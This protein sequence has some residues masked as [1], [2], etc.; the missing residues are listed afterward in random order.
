MDCSA[1]V[2]S[3]WGI[4]RYTTESIGWVSFA[5]AKDELRPGDA[6]NL[7]I[8]RDPEGFGH[9]RLFEAW[10]NEAHTLVWV[11]EETPPRAVHRVV[12]YDDRYQPIRLASLS[13]AAA[14]PLVPAPPPAPEPKLVPT[15]RRSTPS[16]RPTPRVTASRTPTP[17]PTSRPVASAPLPIFT[18]AP[19]V[20]L[21]PRPTPHARAHHPPLAGNR[22]LRA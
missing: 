7:Q 3:T 11:Y 18:P 9:I 6:M 12:V 2:S 4:A 19:S 8:G 16:A 14:A 15:Q 17:A 20:R 1:F 5:I 21:T 22:A 13:N 10:A